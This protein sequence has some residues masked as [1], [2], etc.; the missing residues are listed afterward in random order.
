MLPTSTRS[1]KYRAR[2]SK[3]KTGW[4]CCGLSGETCA[5]VSL[6]ADGHSDGRAGGWLSSRQRAAGA[7]EF[8]RK[9]LTMKDCFVAPLC[10]WERCACEWGNWDL[11]SDIFLLLA[12]EY[13]HLICGLTCVVDSCSNSCVWWYQS[14]GRGCSDIPTPT[15]RRRSTR[16]KSRSFSWNHGDGHQKTNNFLSVPAHFRLL[17]VGTCRCHGSRAGVCVRAT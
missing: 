3:L 10:F 1:Q 11:S 13:L 12:N 17:H 15:D 6:T 4:G 14:N 9:W 7:L 8:L 16:A 2:I 5:T